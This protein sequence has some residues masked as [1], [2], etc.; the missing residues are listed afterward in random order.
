MCEQ[1]FLK[2]FVSLTRK[3]VQNLLSSFNM[4]P[5]VVDPPPQQQM[6][7]IKRTQTEVLYAFL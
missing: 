4:E 6:K 7:I 1:T 2:K 3:V 5:F